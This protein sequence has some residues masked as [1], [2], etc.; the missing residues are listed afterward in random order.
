MYF[1]ASLHLLSVKTLVR[2]V[3]LKNLGIFQM[4]SR[5]INMI[6]LLQRGK[7]PAH[8]NYLSW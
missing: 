6:T 5:S 8:E 4:S 3:A 2:K 7:I 1:I